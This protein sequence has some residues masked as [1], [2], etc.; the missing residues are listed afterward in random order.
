[1]WPLLETGALVGASYLP[2][3]GQA[4]PSDITQSLAK[5]ARMHG[6]KLVEGVR[7]TGFRMDGDRMVLETDAGEVATRDLDR[8]DLAEVELGSVTEFSQ[9]P[10]ELSPG[11]HSA[12]LTSVGVPHL[13]IQVH[14]AALVPVEVR[15][16]ELRSH[17]LLSPE[18]ANVNFVAED[19]DGWSLRTFER[20]VEAETL[21]CGTGSVAC[22]AV[23][24]TRGQISLPWAVRTASGRI[25]TING[26]LDPEGRLKSATLTGEG[27][28]VFRAVLE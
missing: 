5:G 23:L 3:D 8:D 4:S 18:G 16:R 20:G 11:E 25:L 7:V 10:L 22:A 19:P 12:V 6:A 2:T 17:P 28:I 27:R 14:D 24:A 13:V 15:G 9:P 26:T 21:A 1:V